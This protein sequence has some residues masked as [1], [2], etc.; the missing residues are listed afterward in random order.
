MYLIADAGSG[1]AAALKSERIPSTTDRSINGSFIIKTSDSTDLTPISFLDFL[2]K[3][4][5]KSA[6]QRYF[7]EYIKDFTIFSGARGFCADTF[8]FKET[9]HYPWKVNY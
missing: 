1:T 7:Q 5:L 3:K 4:L 6:I 2:F 9:Y 8:I